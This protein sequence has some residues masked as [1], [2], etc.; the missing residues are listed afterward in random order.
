MLCNEFYTS[1]GLAT[2]Q[3][4]GALKVVLGQATVS[5]WFIMHV[6]T[7]THTYTHTYMYSMLY[8]MTKAKLVE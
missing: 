1:T 8:L 5:V 6:Q 3:P 2:T 7:H 4:L